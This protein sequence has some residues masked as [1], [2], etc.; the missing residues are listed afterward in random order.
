MEMLKNNKVEKGK[1][2]AKIIR[3]GMIPVFIAGFSC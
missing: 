3:W 2:T 1:R